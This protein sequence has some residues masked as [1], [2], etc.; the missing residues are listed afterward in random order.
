M[1]NE[2]ALIQL[3]QRL[4]TL[5]AEEAAR[6]EDFARKL[7]ELVSVLP[8]PV[9]AKPK[10]PKAALPDIHAEWA[11]RGDAGFLAW[12]NGLPAPVLRAII[13]REDLD[14][15]RKSARWRADKLADMIANGLAGRRS[16]GSG[17]L[18]EE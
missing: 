4:T 6:N 5:L 16:R 18:T 15:A 1:R 3:F 8:Q 13:K 12:L 14:P 2:S 11:A 17:F 10:A 9:L 7:D